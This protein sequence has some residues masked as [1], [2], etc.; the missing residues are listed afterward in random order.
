MRGHLEETPAST[1]PIPRTSV[2]KPPG[3]TLFFNSVRHSGRPAESAL[4]GARN[5]TPGQPYGSGSRLARAS[6]MNGSG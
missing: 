5:G 3:P 6:W 4:P 1:R 2:S